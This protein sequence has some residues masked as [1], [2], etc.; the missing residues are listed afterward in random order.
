[1]RLTLI[2]NGTVYTPHFIGTP[3]ILLAGDRIAKLGAIDATQVQALGLDC[4]V[5]DA[6]GCSV[7]PG[8]IDP[9]AHLIGA[10]GEHGFT[11][12][13]PEI[14]LHEIVSA[15]VTTVVGLLGTDTVTRHLECL[16]AKTRQLDDEGITAY[17]YTGGFEL[18]PS[19]LTGSV[20]KDVVMIDK[21][22][23]AGEIAIADY[24]WVD[25]LLDPLAHLVTETMLGGMMAGKAGV[26]HFHTGE[27]KQRLSLLHALLDNYAI[28]PRCLYATHITRSHDLMDDAITLA[29]RGAFV[30]MDTIEENLGECLRYYV[31]HDGLLEQ[32][33]VSSDAHTPGGS[34][35]KLYEQLVSCIQQ[36]GFTLAEILPLFTSN[37]A[38]VLKLT[39]KGQLAVDNE[40]D[41]LILRRDTLEI[42]HLFARGKPFIKDG[43][44]V[45]P[46]QQ[47]EQVAESKV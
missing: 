5:I 19:T 7:V 2:E 35:R 37:T 29:R 23:G 22:I 47:E 13:M 46:S 6:T 32:L 45:E 16:H 10:G 21:V 9:H 20:M 42:V 40:A 44:L 15:G 26:T 30:D 36:H 18:P 4:E 33:T 25:P 24:R 8:L 14:A 41:V 3:S 38:R 27:G 11:S 43:R 28:P 1:M 34:Q 17:M 39:G 31:A 12:R